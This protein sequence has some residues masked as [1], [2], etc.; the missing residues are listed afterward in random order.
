MSTTSEGKA[1]INHLLVKIL[2][3]CEGNE[4]SSEETTGCKASVCEEYDDCSQ[5]G[6]FEKLLNFLFRNL[7]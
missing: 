4:E 1:N 3:L 6:K 7:F 2:D 5:A